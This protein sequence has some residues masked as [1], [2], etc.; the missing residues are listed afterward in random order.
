MH[1]SVY[2]SDMKNHAAITGIKLQHM[3]TITTSNAVKFHWQFL[4]A[5]ITSS[6]G[7]KCVGTHGN[8]VPRPSNFALQHSR[9]LKRGFLSGNARSWA[10][11][12][13][14]S[15]FPHGHCQLLTSE[16]MSVY[17]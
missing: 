2:S 9:A 1:S 10:H 5:M 4:H 3:T 12:S 13:S 7:L 14:L 16:C 8:A 6:Q 17:A 15:A 11:K